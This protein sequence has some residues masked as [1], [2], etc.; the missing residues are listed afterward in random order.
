MNAGT[1]NVVCKSIS[2]THIT[3][4]SD[5]ESGHTGIEAMPAAGAVWR[6][7]FTLGTSLRVLLLLLFKASQHPQRERKKKRNADRQTDRQTDKRHN[8]KHNMR[9]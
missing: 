2:Q 3:Y 1:Y 4:D 7:A 6:V 9:A 5:Q 8:H